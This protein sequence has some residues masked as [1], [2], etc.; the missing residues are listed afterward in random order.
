MILLNQNFVV[1]ERNLSA[2]KRN[3]QAAVARV[4]LARRQ[5]ALIESPADIQGLARIRMATN[6]SAWWNRSMSTGHPASVRNT[7]DLKLVLQNLLTIP[8]DVHR[9]LR[10]H[11]LSGN[12]LSLVEGACDIDLRTI[13]IMASNQ[14]L[15]G[16]TLARRP[17]HPALDGRRGDQHLV[18]QGTVLGTS[19]GKV[20][21][22]MSGVDLSWRQTA[23][24][25][26]PAD[27]QWLAIRCSSRL[28][29]VWRNMSV[30]A[31]HPS[32]SGASENLKLVLVKFIVSSVIP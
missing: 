26:R 21:A 18:L 27:K 11:V 32:K 9:L 8:A 13:R 5:T 24:V 19:V 22:T 30:A 2:S 6:H 23:L 7:K 14:T 10:R 31:R 1:F 28:Y 16:D 3:I 29:G 12:L 17:T 25:V 4:N 20:Q 15:M